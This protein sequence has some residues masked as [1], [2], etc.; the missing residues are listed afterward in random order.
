M[1]V[2][3]NR[4]RG[5]RQN[6]PAGHLIGR[7]TGN[8]KA[9]L[10]SPSDIRKIIGPGY[11]K[12]LSG[13]PAL[14]TDHIFVG[15]ASN[16]A[17]DVAM[18]GDATIVA[19]GTLTLASTA[20]T[21]GT[22]GDATHSPQI[23]VD[24]KGRITAA[25][26][27]SITGGGGGSTM[28]TLSIRSDSNFGPSTAALGLIITPTMALSAVG[29]GVVMTT[30]TSG[31]YK[32]GIAP[33]NTGTNKITGTPT[34]AP[35]YTESAGAANRSIFATFSSPVAMSAGTA[36]LLIVVRTDATASTTTT[37]NYQSTFPAQAP[38]IYIPLT[39]VA[40][41][42]ASLAPTTS[43]TWTSEGSGIWAFQMVY[44]L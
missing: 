21:P 3:D 12:S 37:I 31:T 2:L 8:G 41:A 24:A 38:G 27:V 9:Q 15:N 26:N 43:D 32:I 44:T 42:L 33:Y 25:S 28:A 18:S 40:Y 19:A 14:T 35:T 34:Y 23:T 4:V 1:S 6:V 22:Y 13:T 11:V 39:G 5:I 20:V 10:L 16:V 30:V 7:G 29:L 17:T 36:Y